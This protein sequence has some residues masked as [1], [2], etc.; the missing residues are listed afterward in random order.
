[1]T[2]TN[3]KNIYTTNNYINILSGVTLHGLHSLSLSPAKVNFLFHL[4][5]YAAYIV[6]QININTVNDLKKEEK[7]KE[8]IILT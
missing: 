3:R 4:Y 2:Y 7:N 8:K 6:L 5:P 1:M